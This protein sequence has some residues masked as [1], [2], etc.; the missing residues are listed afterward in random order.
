MSRILGTFCVGHTL[1]L[2]SPGLPFTMVC[3][4]ALGTTRE[5]V[6]ADDRFGPGIDGASLAEYSQLFGL[7]DRLGSGDLVADELYLFQYRKFVSPMFGGLQGAA[8]WIRVLT[9]EMTSSV[10]P[11]LDQLDTFSARVAVGSLFEFGESVAANYARVHVVDDLVMF[12]AAC[13]ESGA[14]APPDIR[15]FVE[16]RGILPSP[17]VCYI[18]AD[19]FV[20]IMTILRQVW[21]HHHPHY[22]VNRT[23]YQR[24]VAGYLL[25]RLHSFILLKSLMDQTEPDIR[26]WTRYVVATPE[27]LKAAAA[28]DAAAEPANV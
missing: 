26:T 4:A 25:E 8:P 2:F 22:Q 21:A 12:A 20:R 15:A 7:A 6:L 27:S 17:A 5:I 24:R 9:P 18:H 10:F 28:A 19:L 1:P 3:P 16:M 13:A 23:G 11:S 14:L